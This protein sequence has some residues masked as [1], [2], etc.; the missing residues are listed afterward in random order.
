[1]TMS[2]SANLEIGLKSC[3]RKI[4][5]KSAVKNIGITMGDPQ[6]IGPEVIRKALKS[7]SLLKSANFVCIGDKKLLKGISVCVIDIPYKSA[8][9]G[10][11]QFLSRGVDLIKGGV[12]DALV[13]A[14]LSKERVNKFHKGFRGHTEYLADAFDVKRFDMMF[15]SNEMRLSLVTRHVPLKDVPKMITKQAVL[16]SIELMHQTLKERFKI[17]K[18]RIAVLGLNPHAGENGL[19][20]TEDKRAI[21]PAILAAKKNGIKADGPF[22]A[23]TFFISWG[24]GLKSAKKAGQ[25]PCDGIVAMYHDQG[26]APVKG[27]YFKN[28]VNFT[29]G[30][31]FVRTSPVH[32]TAFDIAGRG[33]ADP[34]SMI[35][36]IQL[37]VCL[38]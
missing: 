9:E 4:M 3:V 11:L 32:G 29:A 28:L 25:S 2:F 24:T 26:L 7:R 34:S 35:A 23:D 12:L 33:I 17:T 6:G 27:L 5:S 21:L 1:M 13:T 22:P 8:G 37:A 15:I 31:P 19:L 14:P 16:S 18:P 20:G 10:S 30:L 36:S 38:S